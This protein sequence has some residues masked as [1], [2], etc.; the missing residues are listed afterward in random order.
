VL[1][2]EIRDFVTAQTKKGN[3]RQEASFLEFRYDSGMKISDYLNRTR[4][5]VIK[6]LNAMLQANKLE[7]IDSKL[8]KKYEA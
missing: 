3:I 6:L 4:A 5:K 8:V 7:P 2:Q 1:L